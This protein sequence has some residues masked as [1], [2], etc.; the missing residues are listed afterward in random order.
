MQSPIFSAAE[1]APLV[2]AFGGQQP[3]NRGR[4]ASSPGREIDIVYMST[5]LSLDE[6][7]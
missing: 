1:K 6:Y 7:Q 5:I 4:R 3:V 2:A